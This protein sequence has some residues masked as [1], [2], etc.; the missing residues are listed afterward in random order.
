MSVGAA[1]DDQPKCARLR[2]VAGGV[3]WLDGRMEQAVVI[4]DWTLVREGIVAVLASAGVS[5]REAAG[6]ALD[7]LLGLG[8]TD[9]SV[10]VVGSCADSTAL[11]VVRRALA[12]KPDLRIIALVAA[13]NQRTLVELCSAGAHGVV[14]RGAAGDDLREAIDH[15]RRGQ[16]YL[17]PALVTTLFSEPSGAIDRRGGRFGLTAREQDVLTQLAAGRSNQQIASTLHIGA[18]TVKTHLGNIYAK[19][20]VRRRHQAVGVALEHGLV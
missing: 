2:L 4:D 13:V 7:G 18:E 17:S 11:D 8:G 10:L 19:L 15:V 12:F 1:R 16:R 3:V 5:T 6:T 20:A 9:V 14:P